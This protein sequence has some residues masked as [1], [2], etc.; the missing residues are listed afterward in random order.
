M[1]FQ[2]LQL[3]EQLFRKVASVDLRI[4]LRDLAVLVDHVRDAL[5][6]LVF[7]IRR[8]SVRETDLVVGVAEQRKVESI[9][10][11]E[12]GVLFARVET[13]ADD[14]DVLLLVL[15]GEVPEPGTL[16]RSPSG[17]RF[18]IEPEDKFLAAKVVQAD[19]TSVLIKG[20]KVGSWV[21][22]I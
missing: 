16:G 6:V 7:R 12:I 22:N 19:R 13:R 15:V 14:R 5:R 11:R 18:R 20:R 9:L 2:L 4:R 17:V 10:L 1:R 8:R 3:R 21:A